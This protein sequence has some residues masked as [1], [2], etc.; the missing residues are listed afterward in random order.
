MTAFS[1]M[2]I[3]LQRSNS[4]NSQDQVVKPLISGLCDLILSEF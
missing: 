4:L 1:S 2:E 3:F